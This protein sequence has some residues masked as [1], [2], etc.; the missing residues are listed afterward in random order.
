MKKNI[1]IIIFAFISLN[2]LGQTDESNYQEFLEKSPFNRMYPKSIA[3][4]AAQYFT[5]W[6]KLFSSGPTT[7]KEARLAAISASAAIKC[8]YC[9]K[10]QIIFAKRVGVSDE[11][12]K[13]AVQIA[14]E[15]NRFS[16]LLYGNEFTDEEF[17]KAIGL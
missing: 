2:A 5:D 3:S 7:T 9:I 16:T 13:A 6:N 8:E 17:N 15:V 1:L 4:E 10:A 11:E 14:A 12:I